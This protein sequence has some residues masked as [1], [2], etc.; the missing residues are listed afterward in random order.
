MPELP[1]VETIRRGLEKYLVGHRIITVVVN[2][3]KQISG[4][5][6]AILEAKIIAVKRFGKGLVIDLDNSYSITI[7]VKMTGQLL[8]REGTK[9]IK[10][11]KGTKSKVAIGLL[12]DKYTH[13][14]FE[15]DRGAFLFY[16]DIRQ[17]GW[18]KVVRS[19]SVASQP[20]FKKLGPEPLRDLTLKMFQEM[21]AKRKTPVKQLLLDQEKIAGIG[22]IY[23]N[24][25]LFVAGIHPA[26]PANA[27]TGQEQEKLLVAIEQVLQKGI[28]VGGASEWSYVDALGQAGKYQDFFQIY[29][30]TGQPCKKC[31][32][33][34]VSI[35][36]GGRGTFF[37]P[38]CQK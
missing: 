35:K 27:L 26:R 15:L 9:G 29:H 31:S 20:F 28:D 25:A 18:I 5:T 4:E 32:T 3:P 11:I 30:K 33:T 19:D 16:R 2:L 38:T 23:A 10:R 13:V 7:H 6:Q 17:F 21:L 14:I 34:V 36:M 24:D 12:P 1:E 8:Y 37:C 22:N